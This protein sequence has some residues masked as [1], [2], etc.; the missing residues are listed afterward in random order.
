MGQG[1]HEKSLHLQLNFAT[2]LKLKSLTTVSSRPLRSCL[3]CSCRSYRN[4]EEDRNRK[5]T[6]GHPAPLSLLH[7]L[8]YILLLFTILVTHVHSA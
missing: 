7:S 4:L 2:N 3:D 5:T 1:V 6:Q 8:I